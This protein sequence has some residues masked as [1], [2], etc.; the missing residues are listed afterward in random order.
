MCKQD[1]IIVGLFFFIC[2]LWIVEI[3]NIL[4]IYFLMNT[5][6]WILILSIVTLIVQLGTLKKKKGLQL[7]KSKNRSLLWLGFVLVNFFLSSVT[8]LFSS[9][10]QACEPHTNRCFVARVNV[11]MFLRGSVTYYERTGIFLHSPQTITTAD[12]PNSILIEPMSARIC[13]EYIC[14]N[15][16][17]M[18]PSAKFPLVSE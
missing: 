3:T 12:G 13:D 11:N 9:Y 8:F 1:K 14:V 17:F 16:T 7:K 4:K 2:F 6:G 5:V 15:T 10:R 18:H